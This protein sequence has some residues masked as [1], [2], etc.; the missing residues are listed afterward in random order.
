MPEIH[1]IVLRAHYERCLFTTPTPDVSQADSLNSIISEGIL[2][3]GILMM[4][5]EIPVSHSAPTCV[6]E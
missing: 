1:A 6:I 4:V 3:F 5:L 2:S